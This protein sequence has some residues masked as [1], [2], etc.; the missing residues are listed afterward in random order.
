M[1]FHDFRL[2][3]GK[4]SLPTI[5]I[6]LKTLLIHLFVSH[7]F[8][9]PAQVILADTASIFVTNVV[10]LKENMKKCEIYE[11]GL[12]ENSLTAAYFLE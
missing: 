7:L 3:L 6:T 1:E 8:C 4:R 10:T 9:K 5:N 2:D 11:D 12:G